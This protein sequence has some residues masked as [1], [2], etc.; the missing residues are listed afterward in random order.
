[1]KIPPG[2]DPCMV[3]VFVLALCLISDSASRSIG[4]RGFPHR[5]FAPRHCRHISADGFSMISM[6]L[7]AVAWFPRVSG[8]MMS[9]SHFTG[10]CIGVWLLFFGSWINFGVCL[11]FVCLVG[12][13]L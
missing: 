13:F 1:M 12:G 6:V 5:S 2:L 10:C 8:V 4:Q 3:S 11:F 7:A 9:V